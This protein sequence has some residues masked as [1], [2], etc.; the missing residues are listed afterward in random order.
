M[1]YYKVVVIILPLPLEYLPLAAL[2]VK[3]SEV[4]EGRRRVPTTRSRLHSSDSS[5]PSRIV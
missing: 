1:G 4:V 5:D 3:A 2:L